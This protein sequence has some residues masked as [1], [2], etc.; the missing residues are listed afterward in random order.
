[1]KNAR[2]AELLNII[3]TAD[4]ETQEQL[5]AE[6]KASGISATQ[7][8]ISRDIQQL[9]LVKELKGRVSYRDA[10]PAIHHSAGA[11]LSLPTIF[12]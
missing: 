3:Q 5:L 2:Q 7:A 12:W 1:M 6:L 11:Y 8:T 9:R 10:Q 4:I